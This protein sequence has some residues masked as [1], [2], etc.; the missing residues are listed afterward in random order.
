MNALDEQQCRENE[1]EQQGGVDD[2]YTQEENAAWEAELVAEVRRAKGGG[3]GG[4][5]FQR[6]RPPPANGEP[7]R[8]APNDDRRGARHC[9]NCSGVH[10]ETKCPHPEVDR[11]D[12]K[13]WIC[14]KTLHYSA[15]CP[16]KKP[17]ASL[18]TV[19]EEAE[20]AVRRIGVVGYAGSKDGYAPAR[21]TFRPAP[22]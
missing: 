1:Q 4:G 9:P 17:G 7:R 15:Q 14:R 12:R 2:G 11:K 10:A 3:K 20:S 18:R 22:R 5:R 6:R 13:L 19:A 21:K 8:P 16:S